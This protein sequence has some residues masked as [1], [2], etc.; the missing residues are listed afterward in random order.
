MQLFLGVLMLE[1][2]SLNAK[3]SF[4]SKFVYILLIIISPSSV[5]IAFVR[6]FEQNLVP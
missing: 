2:N 5:D 4:L 1:L 3:P 6:I